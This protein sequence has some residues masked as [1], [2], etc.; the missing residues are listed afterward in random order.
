MLPASSDIRS[1]GSDAKSLLPNNAGRYSQRP[2]P[3]AA[4]LST[5]ELTLLAGVRARAPRL[6]ELISEC[7]DTARVREALR[8]LHELLTGGPAPS[9]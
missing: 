4:G 1:L 3:E 2:T 8:E 5:A 7:A 6:A 9:R